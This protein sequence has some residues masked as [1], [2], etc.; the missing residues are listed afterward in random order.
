MKSQVASRYHC[1]PTYQHIATIGKCL[2][3]LLDQDVD[4]AYEILLGEDGSRDGTREL[5]REYA[6]KYPEKIRLFC[7]AGK[8]I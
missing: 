3:S 5:C 1:V 8:T 2:D 4:F 6:N 7:I